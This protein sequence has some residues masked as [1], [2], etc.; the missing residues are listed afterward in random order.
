MPKNASPGLNVTMAGVNFKNPF[1]VAALGSHFGKE[2]YYDPKL[3]AEITADI[4]LK[5][6]KA[7]AG[8]IYVAGG[9]VSDE[10]IRKLGER[11]KIREKHEPPPGGIQSRAM[12][13]G[14]AVAPEGME[15]L[16]FLASPFWI[17]AERVKMSDRALEL[18]MKILKEKAPDDVP[19]IANTIGF[20]DLPDTWVDGARRWEEL[21]ADMIEINLSCPFPPALGGAVDDY[22]QRRFQ[23]HFQGM[24]IGDDLDTA[25]EITR[26]VVS[27]VNLP[28]GV[29][30]SPETGFPRVVGLAKRLRDAGAQFVQSF[31]SAVG[32]APPDI[33]NRGKSSW[34]FVEGNPFCMSSGSW[35]RFPCYRNVAA[36]ARFVPE[37]QIAAAGGLMLPEH[38]IEV[39]MLGAT[40]TELCT[41]VIEQGRGL[42]RQSIDFMKKFMIEQGYRSPQDFIG[43]GQKYITYNEDANVLANVR[44]ELD[45]EKCT[46]CGRCINTMCIATHSEHGKIK[47]RADRCNG[48]G[49]CI[50]ACPSGALKLVRIE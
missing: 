37:L 36:I 41:G 4:A 19:I 44:C 3:Y 12:K 38:C 18:L 47:I 24:L 32:I 1:G 21:G 16:F 23:P 48:C 40:L 50:V 49:A 39:M 9:M 45:E 30:I 35:L 17:D 15:G 34:P 28:V 22:F 13:A 33:Y 8:Y 27:A 29:K 7:G 6:I 25:E 14:R 31:N 5:H 2:V 10:T 46:R 42:M 43:I 26:Q 11:S 20:G